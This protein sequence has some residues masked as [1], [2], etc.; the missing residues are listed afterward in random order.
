MEAGETAEQ[1]AI[2]ETQEEFGIT[3]TELIPLT[4][5]TGLA[6][7][8]GTPA[9]FLCTEYDGDVRCDDHSEM[10]APQMSDLGA[11]L[12]EVTR[13]SATL[14]P[15]FADSIRVLNDILA[16]EIALEEEN[17]K[18]Y[19]TALPFCKKSVIIKET[20]GGKGSGNFGHEGRPG[21]IGGSGGGG[22]IEPS[23]EGTNAPCTGF[24]SEAK[25][26]SHSRRHGLGVGTKSDEEYRQKGID[27]LKQS[28]GDDVIGYARPDG[29][30][31]RFNTKTCEY[32]AGKPGGEI[33]TYMSPKCNKKTGKANPEKA[34]NYYEN[35]KKKDGA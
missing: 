5:R 35:F 23:A 6:E 34:M 30:I 11:V 27:F 22:S 12:G 18:V 26:K 2:R 24:A 25:L 7:E 19:E 13:E 20:D 4:V 15:P 28:C 14:F 10:V 29:S 31:V 17:A 33:Y 9:Y 1:A 8:F 21:E 32:A 3:P 16:Q